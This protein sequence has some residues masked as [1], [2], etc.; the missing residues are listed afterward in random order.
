MCFLTCSTN[1]KKETVEDLFIEVTEKYS[2][3]SRVRTDFGGENILVWEHMNKKRGED[4][5]SA[6]VGSSTQ[7]QRIERLWQDAV[8]LDVSAAHFITPLLPW[9]KQAYSTAIIVC[10]CLFSNMYT[11]QLTALPMHGTSIQ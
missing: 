2:W 4:R 5:G 10:T 8:Y 11:L 6:L 7:N 9:R 3:P 1:N